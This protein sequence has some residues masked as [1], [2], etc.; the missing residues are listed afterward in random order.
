MSE[1][2][3]KVVGCGSY[4]PDRLVTNA[5]LAGVVETDDEWI[6]S[7]TGI[8]QRYLAHDNQL[9]SDLGAAA[10]E[11]A[12]ARSGVD[13]RDVDLIIVATT[14]PDDTFPATAASVQA[15]LGITRGAAFDIQ[16]VCAGFVFSLAVA[17]A[18]IRTGQ[19]RTALVVGA[20]TYSR[21]LDWSDRSTCVLFGDGAGAVVLQADA[22]D[23]AVRG[24][25]GWGQERGVISTHLHTDGRY[26]D[27]LF[28]DGGPSRTQ[29]VGHL[30]MTGKDVFRHAVANLTAV[31]DEALAYNG[32]T[33]DMVS[34]FVPHQA[35]Q[36]IIDGV[37]KKLGL[38]ANRIIST[39]D[40]HANTS[41]ASIPLAL[42]DGVD[43]GL[44]KEGDLL[45]MLA[46][47]GGLAWGGALVRW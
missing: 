22:A 5:D 2:R 39:V 1:F 41:A 19:Y 35:N 6:V 47:G 28:V 16:A 21:I 33:A 24:S 38:G 7:R 17:D 8:R 23:T 42:D 25:P 44:I 13:R 26:R 36:R 29:T 4:L 12:L 3:A 27:I 18:L 9:T 14:T 32:M 46:I 15:K 30:R 10:A 20:E 45:L 37:A 11:R 43:R 34:W 31:A 40:R